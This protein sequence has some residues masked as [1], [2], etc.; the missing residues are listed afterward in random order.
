MTRKV[1]ELMTF[2]ELGNSTT[3]SC[4][5]CHGAVHAPGKGNVFFGYDLK[6]SKSIFLKINTRLLFICIM[7]FVKHKIVLKKLE[8]NYEI[9]LFNNGMY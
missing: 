5:I 2:T 8:N 7:H 1:R 6:F 9:L 3:K 4:P